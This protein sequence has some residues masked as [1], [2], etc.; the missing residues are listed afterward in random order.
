MAQLVVSRDGVFWS[1]Y[2]LLFY[3]HKQ[4]GLDHDVE[5]ANLYY[6]VVES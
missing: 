2:F 3:C 5:Y 6:H 4:I 1:F